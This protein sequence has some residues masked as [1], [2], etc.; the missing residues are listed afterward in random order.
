M[1]DDNEIISTMAAVISIGHAYKY[2]DEVIMKRIAY[3]LFFTCVENNKDDPVLYLDEESVVSAIYYDANIHS[4]EPIIYNQ[5]LWLSELYL[6]IQRKTNMTFEAIFLYLPLNKGYGM[7]PLYHEMDFSQGVDY[8]VSLVKSQ[9]ILSI[10]M[11]KKAIGIE[12]AARESGLSYSMVASLKQK[13]KDITKV[14]ASNLLMMA[15]YLGVKPE[16]LIRCC[17]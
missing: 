16:T 11:K 6:Q 9:S 12:E 1:L 7:F 13:K 17:D 10:I 2:S 15:S 3:S 4:Y 5:S 8:Y 14:A